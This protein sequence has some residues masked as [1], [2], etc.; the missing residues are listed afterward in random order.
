MRGPL[1]IIFTVSI[2]HLQRYGRL[3]NDKS[4]LWT[5]PSTCVFMFCFVFVNVLR[6]GEEFSQFNSPFVTTFVSETRQ[7][8]GIAKCRPTGYT[9][10]NLQCTWKIGVQIDVS[11]V[12]PSLI[13]QAVAFCCH[14]ESISIKSRQDVD[15]STVYKPS[16]QIIFSIT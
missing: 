3:S 10:D 5:R 2:N 14:L 16:H 13:R 4:I 12:I 11:C 15:T 6:K 9:F 8:S 7:N 1:V